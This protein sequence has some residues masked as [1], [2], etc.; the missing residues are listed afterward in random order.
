MM[1]VLLD[2]ISDYSRMDQTLAFDDQFCGMKCCSCRVLDD[3]LVFP[4][5]FA[6]NGTEAYG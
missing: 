1:G 3:T 5:I 2:K 4:S 6:F